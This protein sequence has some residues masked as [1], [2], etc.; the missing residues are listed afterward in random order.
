L[1]SKQMRIT[2]DTLSSIN[3]FKRLVLLNL[4]KEPL[5]PFI[6]RL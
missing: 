5:T 1:S 4:V 3:Q 2:S 6:F